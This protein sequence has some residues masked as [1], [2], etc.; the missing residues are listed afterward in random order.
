MAIQ[1]LHPRYTK[2]SHN[3][4][5]N[6]HIIASTQLINLI[7]LWN[8]LLIGNSCKSYAGINVCE[9]LVQM[10]RN[11]DSRLN[12]NHMIYNKNTDDIIPKPAPTKCGANDLI[13]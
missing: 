11:N 2:S 12:P 6:H 8:R 5:P 4:L 7:F 1:M 13:M 3:R 10:S 9:D